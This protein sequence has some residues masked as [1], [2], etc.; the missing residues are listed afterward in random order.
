MGGALGG[1]S[2]DN[3][4]SILVLDTPL[5][6]PKLFPLLA[7][8]DALDPLQLC[9]ELGVGDGRLQGRDVVFLHVLLPDGQLGL[10]ALDQTRFTQGFGALH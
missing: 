8:P 4:I 3:Q 2:V 7:L 6:L 9:L 10:D 5:V 1:V